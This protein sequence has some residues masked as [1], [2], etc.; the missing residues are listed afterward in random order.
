MATERRLHR[1]LLPW[2]PTLAAAELQLLL[3]GHA[4]LSAATR[5][6]T[7]ARAASLRL[8]CS[9]AL[10][11]VL[12]N[13]LTVTEPCLRPSGKLHARMHRPRCM[14]IHSALEQ[15]QL[16]IRRK[17]YVRFF[18]CDGSMSSA[19]CC[20]KDFR[21]LPAALRCNLQ[22]WWGAQAAPDIRR[23]TDSANKYGAC[24]QYGA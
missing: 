15:T 19:A 21:G 1:A 4:S 8:I 18:I 3:P 10:I 20:L 17:L 23:A 13:C 9:D 14:V 16:Q 22:G 24:D 6:S 12:Q 5:C 2:V 7:G 11:G